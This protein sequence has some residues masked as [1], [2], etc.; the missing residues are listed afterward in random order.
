[1][2]WTIRIAVDARTVYRACRRGTGKNLIDLYRNLARLRP[3]WRFVLFHQLAAPEDPFAGAGRVERRQID[4]RGGDRLNLW[5]QVRLPL[6]ARLTGADVL[7]CPANTGARWSPVP[8]VLTVH[9][10]IPLEMDPDSAT[11]RRWGAKVAA[12]ARRARRVLTP[13]QYSKEQLV[14]RLGVSPS[15]VRVNYWAPD[16]ACRRVADPAAWNRAR[17]RYG[18]PDDQPYVLGFGAE[19]PRKNTRRILEAWAGLPAR[20]R[21]TFALLLV[22]IQETVLA[23]Y[24]RLAAELSLTPDCSL[25]GFAGEQDLPALMSGAA[26]LCYPSLSEGFGLPIL[27]AFT[28]GTAVLTSNVTSL[29]EV[30]GDAAV[31]VNPRSA[32][33]I[34]AGLEQLLGDERLRADLVARGSERVKEFTWDRTAATAAATLEEAVGG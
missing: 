8:L 19:D 24:R 11:A 32:S 23:E 18:L 21:A 1:V 26:A 28:C 6:A 4:I 30:A 5:E 3:G 13:S 16:G 12:A 22:G 7:H 27:D 25:Q 17:R 14:R 29:P 20:L 34:R 15:K 10:L 33:A 31:L 2:R 9:D